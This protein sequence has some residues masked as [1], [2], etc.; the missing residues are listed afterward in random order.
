MS[1][2]LTLKYATLNKLKQ[3][4]G[5]FRLPI[6][7]ASVSNFNSLS[8]DHVDSK[9]SIISNRFAWRSR[10][11]TIISPC[12]RWLDWPWP[13]S[14][15]SCSKTTSSK[16]CSPSSTNRPSGSHRHRKSANGPNIPPFR[17]IFL[18]FHGK[19]LGRTLS[20][21]SGFF[22]GDL[23]RQIDFSKAMQKCSRNL[24]FQHPPTSPVS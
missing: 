12:R 22:S 16:T 9:C 21:G 2:K 17:I 8:A 7:R 10:Q 5:E 18:L 15:S 23:Q 20:T 13:A 6:F 19:F 1:L 14:R 3:M 11:R 24:S 4:I